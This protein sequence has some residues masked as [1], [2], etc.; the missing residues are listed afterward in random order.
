MPRVSIA[1]DP[2]SLIPDPR[3]RMRIGI[4]LGGT[5]IEGI[6]LDGSAEV[7]RFRVDTPRGDYA[8]TVDAVAALVSALEKRAGTR[9]SVGVGIP[10]TLS[11]E[12]GLVKNANSVWLI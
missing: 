8:A 11:P 1:F 4:D 9:G 10:G 6:A 12:N 7:A 2:R 5:K 3:S